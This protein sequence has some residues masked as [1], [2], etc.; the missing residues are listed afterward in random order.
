[1]KNSNERKL[2]LKAA[3][4]IA[5]DFNSTHEVGSEIAIRNPDGTVTV[6]TIVREAVAGKDATRNGQI[7]IAI[8]V[9]VEHGG[10][11]A[12]YETS[13]LRNR[14]IRRK[15]MKRL[16]RVELTEKEKLELGKNIADRLQA[17]AEL[18][19]NLDTVRKEIQ[20]DIQAAEAECASAAA[21]LR[22]GYETRPVPCQMTTDYD[23]GSVTVTRE[24]TNE[25]IERR[26][27][28]DDERQTEM[29]LESEA[30]GK[31]VDGDE[32]DE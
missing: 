3:K 25:V 17:A 28:R 23:I 11:T 12:A 14:M 31:S 9:L 16:L 21:K 30:E 6:G 4:A 13:R 7:Q 29:P 10:A 19:S 8:E 20:A 27:L 18:Q 1:M 15:E 22:S 24:D 2:T 26:E 5:A 32:Q